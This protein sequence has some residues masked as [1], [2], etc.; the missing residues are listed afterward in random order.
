MVTTLDARQGRVPEQ[1]GGEMEVEIRQGGGRS[2][3]GGFYKAREARRYGGGEVV[4]RP[5]VVDASMYRLWEW[6]G[7]RRRGD[8]GVGRCHEGQRKR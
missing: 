8:G 3:L 1:E 2:G 5:V 4:W 7:A 6:M